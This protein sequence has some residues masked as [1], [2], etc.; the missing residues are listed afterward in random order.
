MPDKK[1]FRFVEQVETPKRLSHSLGVMQVMGELANVYTLD[2]EKA[3]TIGLLH[4]AA[5]DI[6][7]AWQK[8][9]IA[10]GHIVTHYEC[11]HNYLFYLHAPVGS[12]LV[13]K[14][15]GLSDPVILDAITTHSFY[16]D[17]QNFN[18]PLSWCMRFSDMLEPGRDWS[19]WK[20]F[21]NGVKNLQKIVYNG[22]MKESIPLYCEILIRWYSERSW[23]VHPNMRKARQEALTLLNLDASALEQYFK[24]S[25]D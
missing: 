9:L 10:E 13:Q 14:E 21:Q 23:P 8:Q 25:V 12:Y 7:L 15:L 5:K 22:Q 1:Y 6:P 16:G 11:D 4:D 18:H 3:Q 17:G 2:V 20:W 24:S 19:R